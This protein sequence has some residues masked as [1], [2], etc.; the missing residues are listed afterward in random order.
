MV[1]FLE[2]AYWIKLF[3]QFLDLFERFSDDSF[4]RNVLGDRLLSLIKRYL[5]NDTLH[6]Y[7]FVTL[8]PAVLVGATG[9][10]W[11]IKDH[12]EEL[13]YVRVTVGEND[14]IYTPINEY[15]TK[16]FKGVDRLRRVRGKTGYMEPQ[17]SS[18]NH[19]FFFFE[20]PR[21]DL[22]NTPIIDLIPG[23]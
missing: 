6:I 1:Y 22:G 23:I 4:W 21:I 7:M 10:F 9:G 16:H 11:S 20:R 12:F 5:I 15:I 2:G 8:L 17:D 18:H 13:F 14:L 3:S 19:D